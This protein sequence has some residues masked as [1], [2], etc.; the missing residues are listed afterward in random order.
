MTH[1]HDMMAENDSS[2]SQSA[3]VS[4]AAVLSDADED[5]DLSAGEKLLK[6]SR[7]GEV[8]KVSQMFASCGDRDDNQLSFINCKG[9]ALHTMVF[10]THTANRCLSS[11]KHWSTMLVFSCSV[12][13]FYKTAELCCCVVKYIMRI[14]NIQVHV[15]LHVFK[16]SCHIPPTFY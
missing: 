11:F 13:P 7:N 1:T 8:A 6:Y 2:Q 14:S 4:R 3:L 9:I 16:Y 5:E 10:S 12:A 15:G